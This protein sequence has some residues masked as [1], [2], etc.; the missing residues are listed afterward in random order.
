VRGGLTLALHASRFPSPASELQAIEAIFDAAGAEGD[1]ATAK[2]IAAQTGMSLQTVRRRLRLRS[3][4][5]GLRAAFDEG[6]ISASVAE[7]ATRLPQAQQ[8]ILE[9][10]LEEAARLTLSEVRDVAR[11]QTSAATS[12]LPGGVFEEQEVS[13]QVTVR[14]HLTAALRAMPGGEEHEALA[15]LVRDA[16]AAGELGDEQA[17]E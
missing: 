7:A 12:E 13:W 5:P 6:R 9:R 15:Q 8:S 4:T 1:V 16:L 2:E 11:E 14:G 10:K 3:L 17:R